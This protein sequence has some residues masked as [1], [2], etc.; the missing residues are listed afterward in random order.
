MTGSKI[1]RREKIWIH[2]HF[3]TGCMYLPDHRA[4]EIRRKIARV[5]DRLGIVFGIHF[6]SRGDEGLRIVLECIP[7]PETMAQIESA[8]AATIEPMPARP[9][10]TKV[11][12]EPEVLEMGE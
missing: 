6:D 5:L 10:R 4:R 9:R 2:A 12:I 1:P 7:F 3:V 8:L 11:K